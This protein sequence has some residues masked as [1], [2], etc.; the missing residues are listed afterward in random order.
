[1][2]FCKICRN[3]NDKMVNQSRATYF[4]ISQMNVA[5]K[6]E[7]QYR[8][9]SNDKREPKDSRALKIS[10]KCFFKDSWTNITPKIISLMD[11]QLHNKQY[12]PLQMVKQRIID[13]IQSQSAVNGEQAWSIHDEINPVVTTTA[14]FD[15]LLV[16]LDHPSRKKSDSYYI[17][18][19]HMLRAHT[20]AHQA[21]LIKMGH[22]NFL[23]VGDV[24]RRD[25]IDST[26]YPVFHQIEG[27]RLIQE[28]DL[29]KIDKSS[30]KSAKGF[31]QGVKSE[32]KQQHHTKDAV[33]ILEKNLK[34]CLTAL[35]IELFGPDTQYKWVDCYFP[36]T[37]PSWELE[38][39][40]QGKWLEVLGCGIIEQEILRTAGCDS[41]LGFAFGLGLERLAMILYQIPDIRLF[42]S[43]DSGF[44]K[45]FVTNDIKSKIV[46][47]SVS[48]HPQCVNDISFWLPLP[49]EGYEFCKNDFYDLIRS[50]GGDL[51]EQVECFDEFFHPKKQRESQSYR[52]T[53]RHMERTLTQ[54]EVNKIHSEIEKAAV[55]R[56]NVQIR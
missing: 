54:E 44:L 29:S 3:I 47:S 26:H 22:D 15:S 10:D 30:D 5:N 48:K 34:T 43:N 31:E 27:V 46:Y 6:V 7:C 42:W 12:H 53:Y 33:E 56:L 8:Y 1:M 17:N 24:Y 25:E 32:N 41:K 21:E 51:I 28:R 39:R 45:Q 23:V 20:S 55:S 2:L 19:T 4:Y 50:L 37:H 11:R 36:F 49:Q 52:I 38:I 35:A 16:P 9:V 40:Y 13:Y 18:S 14:N